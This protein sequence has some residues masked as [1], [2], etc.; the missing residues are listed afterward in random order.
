LTNKKWGPCAVRACFKLLRS[1]VQTP[2]DWTRVQ[3]ATVQAFRFTKTDYGKLSG[4][5]FER[6]G[7]VS[8][9]KD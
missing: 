2:A 3:A 5:D 1:T 6:L 8:L 9:G 4:L 7:N